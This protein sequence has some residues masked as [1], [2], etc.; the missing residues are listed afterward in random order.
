MTAGGTTALGEALR[1]GRELILEGP[2]CDEQVIDVSGDGQNNAGLS[3]GAIYA[4][5]DFGAVQV[6]G[7]AIRSYERDIVRYY[8]DEVI[9]GP[10][11]FVEV[12]DGPR[13]FPRAIRR[14]LLRELSEQ[15]MGGQPA[16]DGTARARASST[17]CGGGCGSGRVGRAPAIVRSGGDE[18][19]GVALHHDVDLLADTEAPS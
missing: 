2:S 12:A 16:A 15:M 6:N 9:R 10:D 7:L 3:P 14:K 18:A 19:G 8:E 13:D 11:A 5:E 1:F 17:V 4:L